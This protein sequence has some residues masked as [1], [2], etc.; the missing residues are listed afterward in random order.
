[1]TSD[2]TIERLEGKGIRPTANRIL[3]YKALAKSSM[4]LSLKDMELLMLNLDRSSIFRT[5]TLFLEHDVVHS[6][7][8]GRGVINYE[9]CNEKGECHNHDTHPHFYCEAC[10]RSFCMDDIKIP[11]FNLPEGF[12]AHSMSFVIKGECPQ[13]RKKH[14]HNE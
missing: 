4:P 5:L 8:D 6:F 14:K 11:P 7:E 13:C 10:Q 12:S 9:L 1:M 2:E 3:I